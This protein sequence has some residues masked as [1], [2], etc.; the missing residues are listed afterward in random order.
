MEQDKYEALWLSH[1][2]IR[3]FLNCP[4]AYYL[5]HIYRNPDTGNKIML[6]RP[7]LALG[8]TVH[9]VLDEISGLPKEERFKKSL[10]ARLK[11]AWKKVSG[12]KGGFFNQEV[13][14]KYRR[15]GE[16]MLETVMDKPGPLKKLAVKINMELPHFWLSKEDNYILSG[17]IDWL[18]YLPESDSVHIID[19]KTG[20]NIDDS[21]SLQLPI[22]CLLVE[23]CQT[24]PVERASYWYLRHNKKE[25]KKLLP[26]SESKKKIMKIAQKIKLAIQLNKF[27]CP[28]GEKGCRY[29]RALERIV[30]GEGELVG[31]GKYG[32]DI[33][34]LPKET[35]TKKKATIL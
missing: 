2:K 29:C 8:Q 16:E 24:W 19:F 22:Y 35:T 10:L 28:E 30:D 4:R 14:N 34:V 20:Q 5:K 32:S 23:N 27:S 3:D 26:S 31:T 13:E 6:M 1:T 21:D 11:T 33:F 12:K 9:Q 25:E 17:K 15:E 7:A 18:E